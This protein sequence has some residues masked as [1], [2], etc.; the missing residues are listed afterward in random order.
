MVSIIT[1]SNNITDTMDIDMDT[2]VTTVIMD[3]MD[4]ETVDFIINP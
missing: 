1:K 3:T 2:I 4:M